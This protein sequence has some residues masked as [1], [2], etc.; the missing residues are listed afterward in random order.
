MDMR[1]GRT[2]KRHFITS[3]R[4]YREGEVFVYRTEIYGVTDVKKAVFHGN[5]ARRVRGRD[6][7]ASKIG[8]QMFA[9]GFSY[10]IRGVVPHR[11]REVT[12]LLRDG[13]NTLTG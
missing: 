9:P 7:T 12:A 11:T 5:C 1:N 6:Q 3:D 10:P 2:K 4:E 8:S 13:V